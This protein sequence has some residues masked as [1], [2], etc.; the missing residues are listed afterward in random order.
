M[1]I[2]G[3]K[4]GL[5]IER[6]VKRKEGCLR[7]LIRTK[8]YGE[9]EIDSQDIIRFPRGV[10]AFEEVTDFVLLQPDG[11]SPILRLQAVGRE[12]PRFILFDPFAV[13]PDYRLSA[14][15]DILK[16]LKAES[17]RD[18]RFFA[19]AVV[20]AD[21]RNTTINLKSPVAVNFDAR[22][23][24]QFILDSCDYPIRY[25]IFARGKTEGKRC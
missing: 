6:F 3:K 16:L 8:D 10:Y 17:D 21:I 19:V 25:P 7:M 22:L 24:A 18:L 9:I 5:K 4:P 14:P 20:P 23:G 13:A 11:D 2:N 15:A 12:D 1:W